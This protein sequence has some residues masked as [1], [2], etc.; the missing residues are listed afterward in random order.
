MTPAEVWEALRTAPLDTIAGPYEP[1]AGIRGVRR[2]LTGSGLAYFCDDGSVR[3]YGGPKVVSVHP[4]RA[5]ADAALRAA[6]W[7][8]VDDD[9]PTAG[10]GGAK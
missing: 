3:I 7:L 9:T 5:S 4:D 2:T 6:G 10:T 8:L 1:G